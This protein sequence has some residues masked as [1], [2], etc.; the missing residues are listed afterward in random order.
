M[1]NIMVKSSHHTDELMQESL[2]HKFI[3]R[4]SWLYIIALL[5]GPIGYAIK[6]IISHDLS[7]G[8]LGILYGVLSFILLFGS[9]NDLGMVESLN[10]FLPKYLG[11]GD[12]KKV[13]GY[14]LY[15][16]IA[17]AGMS[18]I[19]S[20]LL[21]FGAGWLADVYFHATAALIPEV[22]SVLQIFAIYLL[23]TNLQH[24]LSTIAIVYQNTFLSKGLELVRLT[25]SLGFAYTLMTTNTG[26]IVAY[27]QGW[28]FGTAIATLLGLIFIGTRYLLPLVRSAPLVVDK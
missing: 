10:Y 14:A 5:T 11:L 6:I 27:A 18:V 3:K 24:Y 21:Y 16:L 8:E 28:L 12:H 4:G 22:T 2:T 7:V 1:A 19:T 9:L 13:K 20:T 26:S 23:F 25:S 15:S 17:M